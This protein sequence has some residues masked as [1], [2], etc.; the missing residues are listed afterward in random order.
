M[1][2]LLGRSKGAS[3]HAMR[4]PVLLEMHLP[5]AGAAKRD[6]SVSC[7]QKWD[8]IREIDSNIYEGK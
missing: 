3:R 6:F 1:Q 5:M 8:F 4:P 7:L 2:H